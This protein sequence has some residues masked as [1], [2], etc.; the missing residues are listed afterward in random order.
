MRKMK[1]VRDIK[2]AV[3]NLK[4]DSGEKIR[5]RVFDKLLAALDKPK[6]HTA[7]HQPNIWRMHLPSLF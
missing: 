5:S 2:K 7:A 1:T 6:N 4:V 3:R